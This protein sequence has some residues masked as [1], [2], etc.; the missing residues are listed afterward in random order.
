MRF[1]L[2]VAFLRA[3]RFT[4]LRSILSVIVFVFAMNS[5]FLGSVPHPTG[6]EAEVGVGFRPFPIERIFQPAFSSRTLEIVP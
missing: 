5:R 6:R 1:A 4:F 3:V 2:G